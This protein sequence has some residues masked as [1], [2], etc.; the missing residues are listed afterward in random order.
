MSFSNIQ[1]DNLILHEDFDRYLGYYY[2]KTIHPEDVNEVACQLACVLDRYDVSV[3]EAEQVL[4]EHNTV[5]LT[6]ETARQ[7]AA[8]VVHV[9]SHKK[10]QT[11]ARGSIFGV[12][13]H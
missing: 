6:P 9:H 12:E 8:E 11:T 13:V 4:V 2:D 3:A 1:P 5:T 10:S 7:L